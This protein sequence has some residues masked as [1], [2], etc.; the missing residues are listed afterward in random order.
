MMAT[1]GSLQR[2]VSDIDAMPRGG[3]DA[4]WLDRRLETRCA[5]YLDRDDVDERIKRSVVRS[6]EWTGE[7][8]KNHERFAYIALD[9]LA[10]VPDPKIIE[11]GAAHGGLSRKLLEEHPTAR[12]TVTDLDAT[13]VVNI[14]ESELGSHPRAVVQLADATEIDCP[15]RSFHLA[16]MALTF[17]HLPPAAASRVIAEGTRVADK[18]LIIDLPRPPSLLHILRL[19]TML[20]FALVP[21]VHDGV[22]S[23][24]RCYSPSALRALAAHAGPRIDIELRGGPLSPQVL[25]ASR[26]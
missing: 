5:E 21:F 3:P 15:D 7:V 8:F 14:A 22:I 1:M 4:S 18:L 24:L 2:S 13:S 11:L 6:L 25:V 26:H 19:A 20:P 23:S 9:E 12:V 10:E 17:H 16:V